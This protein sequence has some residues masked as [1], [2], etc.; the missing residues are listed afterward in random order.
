MPSTVP[1]W[2]LNE[3]MNPMKK[4]G[5]HV[6]APRSSYWLKMNIT[7]TTLA[8]SQRWISR[9]SWALHVCVTFYLVIFGSFSK[10]SRFLGI[11]LQPLQSLFLWF[12]QDYILYLQ[13]SHWWTEEARDTAS[14]PDD[15]IMSKPC[16]MSNKCLFKIKE[17]FSLDA[18]RNI[19]DH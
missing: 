15:V 17:S 10:I 9:P 4:G 11:L 16:S 8:C 3:F 14:P 5:S 12:R 1:G 18:K 19:E 13:F 6:S 2:L 7:L